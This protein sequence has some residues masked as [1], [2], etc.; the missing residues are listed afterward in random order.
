MSSSQTIY[1]SFSVVM[2]IF[3]VLSVLNGII[4]IF[5][6]ETRGRDI[7]D[8]IEDVDKLEHPEE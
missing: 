2:A 6:P 7:P 5:L 1:T 3:G 8:T 4:C